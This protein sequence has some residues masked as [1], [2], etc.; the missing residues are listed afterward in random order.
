MLISRIVQLSTAAAI[1][2]SCQSSF[3]QQGQ[4]VGG[5][6]AGGAASATAAAL[7]AGGATGTTEGI[8]GITTDGVPS[9]D[10]AGG[11][12]GSNTA[13]VFVGGNNTGGF[14]GGGVGTQRNNNRQ[15]QAITNNNVPTGGGGQTS[16]SPRRI[17][18]SLRIAFPYPRQQQRTSLVSAPG[19][20][21]NHI[22]QTRPELRNINV[23]LTANGIAT[24]TGYAPNA[25]T[26]SLAA[27]LVRL[28]PG[29]RRVE[30][31]LSIAAE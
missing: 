24:L 9:G 1:L 7:G 20:V 29:V 17:P 10:T 12:A 6:N 11:T 4:I 3:A 8:G 22:A 15:F 25:D 16:G 2:L 19:P 23:S 28:Q 26:R 27:N 13:E 31:Q 14:V 30:N 21:L 18:V 5:G